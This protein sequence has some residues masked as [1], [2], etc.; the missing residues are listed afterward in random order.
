LIYSARAFSEA[1]RGAGSLLLA[2]RA[3]FFMRKANK[4]MN[5]KTTTTS[6]RPKNKP[7]LPFGF[8]NYI[9][10]SRE[11]HLLRIIQELESIVASQEKRILALEK[12][13]LQ[14]K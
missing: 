4:I 14:I 11:D 7:A 12:D 8:D 13:V 9:T 1:L 6:R 5:N 10:Q 3:A 2:T